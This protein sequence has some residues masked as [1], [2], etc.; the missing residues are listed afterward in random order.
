MYLLSL[1]IGFCMIFL[2]HILNFTL[3]VR[4]KKIWTAHQ[5]NSF[6]LP[7]YIPHPRTE[8]N[9]PLLWFIKPRY[10]YSYRFHVDTGRTEWV[11]AC[12]DISIK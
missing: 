4:R 9:V 3:K 5:V 8:Q 11:T 6:K 1:T 2:G 10:I 7:L 12:T